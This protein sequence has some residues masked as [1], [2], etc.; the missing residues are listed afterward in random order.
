MLRKGGSSSTPTCLIL[1][2]E[3]YCNCI[4]EVAFLADLGKQKA[5]QKMNFN[6]SVKFMA[7]FK[8]LFYET[9]DDGSP[10]MLNIRV[11]L[12]ALV[13]SAVQVTFLSKSKPTCT[14]L[15]YLSNPS[16]LLLIALAVYH[17]DFFLKQQI[18]LTLT[19][20]YSYHSGQMEL[21]WDPFSLV[22]QDMI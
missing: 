9:N 18:Y 20:S 11:S 1:L 7:I 21:S 19:I 15:F 8:K 10:K 4:E 3:E 13:S 5:E 22:C 12:L 17:I 2:L 16:L 6:F 14:F